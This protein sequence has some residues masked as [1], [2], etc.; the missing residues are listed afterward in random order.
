MKTTMTFLFALISLVS[1]AEIKRSSQAASSIGKNTFVEK[2]NA[3]SYIQNGL[4]AQ[5]DGIENV[6]Y[7]H[8]NDA[9][10]WKDLIG[11]ND[12]TCGYSFDENSL[13]CTG[14]NSAYKANPTISQSDIMHIEICLNYPSPLVSYMVANFG[15]N[16]RILAYAILGR[17][18]ISLSQNEIGY[19]AWPIGKHTFSFSYSNNSSLSLFIDGLI[20]EHSTGIDGW[21]NIRSFRIGS[22]R[23]NNYKGFIG[24][25]YCIRLYSRVLTE[26]EINH[27]YSID[28]I[29]FRL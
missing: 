16:Y 20:R 2:I 27:N 29:R 22:V 5:W 1:S 21:N 13:V 12:L 6:E 26:E 15:G 10:I 25:F 8:K 4:I 24:N 18:G 3:H 19:G 17:G 7:G 9:K 11:D 23:G 14:Y 28:K